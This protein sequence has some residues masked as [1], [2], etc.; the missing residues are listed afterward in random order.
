MPLK[1]EDIAEAEFSRSFRGYNEEEVREFLEEV[2]AQLASILEENRELRRK[3]SEMQTQ[4]EEWKRQAEVEKELARRESQMILKEAQ[5]KAQKIVDE[6]LEKK[7]EIEASYRGLFE[8]YRLFQIRFKSLLQTFMESLEKESLQEDMREEDSGTEVV[9][10]SFQDL[11][12]E[13]KIGK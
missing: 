8:K 13:G 10:F 6:A 1:P 11:R 5:L 12:N 2:A 7:R 9:R 4:F 3:L